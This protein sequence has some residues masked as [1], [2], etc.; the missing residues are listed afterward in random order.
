MHQSEPQ[1]MITSVDLKK[2]TQQKSFKLVLVFLLHFFFAS[3][4]LGCQ[5]NNRLFMPATLKRIQVY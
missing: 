5:I 2:K 1:S 3:G 4:F